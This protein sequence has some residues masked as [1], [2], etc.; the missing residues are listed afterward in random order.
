MD[1]K[2]LAH[3]L[4]VMRRKLT[5]F[6]SVF[7][8]VVVVSA[9]ESLGWIATGHTIVGLVAWEDLTPKT[10][11]AVTEL[12]KQHPRYEKDLLLNLP[13]GSTPEETDR[14]AF[15]QAATWPDMVRSLANPMHHEFSHPSW[16]YIDIPFSDGAP[17]D[18]QPSDAPWPHNIVEALQKCSA[19]M[20]DASVSEK[21]R[22]VDICWVEHLVGDI[23]QP[24][25]AASMYSPDHPDGD[26]GGNDDEVLR[27]PPY[28]TSRMNLHLVWDSLPGDFN[29]QMMDGYEA[30]GLRADPQFSRDQLKSL[31]AV[32]DF[33]AW[34]NESHQLAIDDAYLNGKLETSVV[35]KKASDA[36][37]V[38]G[39]PPGYLE[40]AEHVAMH[41]VALAGYRLADLLN[42]SFDPK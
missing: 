40:K 5:A 24:L 33:M 9:R 21:M 6:V 4:A 39:L 34:A 41:Q 22:A 8:A 3:T 37:K 16:H 2:P 17:A 28:P 27:D 42:A 18:T 11:A 10:K 26:K 14:Y 38:P 13:A 32:T 15:A 19:E 25:H 7:L 29:S 1:S 23:H 35:S 20:T 12:L 31:I 30:T 36:A